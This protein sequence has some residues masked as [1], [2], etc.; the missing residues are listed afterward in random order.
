M[1]RNR[2]DFFVKILIFVK[3]LSQWRRKDKKFRSLEVH[4]RLIALENLVWHKK[5]GPAQSILG[6]VKGQGIR[7]DLSKSVEIFESF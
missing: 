7:V 3:I 1:N 5:F 4:R 2:I 6:P